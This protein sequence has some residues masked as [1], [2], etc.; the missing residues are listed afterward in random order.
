MNI[1]LQRSNFVSIYRFVTCGAHTWW[2]WV[3]GV[4][5]GLTKGSSLS[6]T[7]CEQWNRTN[8]VLGAANRSTVER[9]VTHCIMSIELGGGKLGNDQVCTNTFG[10]FRC[11]VRSQK[12]FT[13]RRDRSAEEDQIV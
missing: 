6:S 12:W 3:E 11:N 4:M 1:L 9:S 8:A 7:S 10:H 13:I 2:T 5:P